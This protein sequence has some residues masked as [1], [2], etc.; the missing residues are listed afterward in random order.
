MFFICRTMK[1][2]NFAIR[3]NP[4]GSGMFFILLKFIM[5]DIDNGLNPFG[6]GMFFISRMA[7]GRH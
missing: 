6:S 7:Y 5:E 4:F 1:A 2:L 3:L